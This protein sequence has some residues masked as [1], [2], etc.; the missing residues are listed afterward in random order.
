[1]AAESAPVFRSA[2]ARGAAAL[3]A[4]SVAL[5]EWCQDDG[6]DTMR[7]RL[8]AALDVLDGSAA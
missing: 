1:M 4:L 6:A 2:N 8:G 3:A 7:T 5:L